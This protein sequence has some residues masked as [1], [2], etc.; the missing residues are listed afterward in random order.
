M[1]VGCFVILGWAV[2]CGSSARLRSSRVARA[3]TEG[4][5]FIVQTGELFS[6]GAPA[7]TRREPPFAVPPP[8]WSVI[9]PG[10]GQGQAGNPDVN[11]QEAGAGPRKHGNDPSREASV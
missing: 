7:W 10:S 6:W 5:F 8:G 4:R 9:L 3:G 1:L 2:A 11:L